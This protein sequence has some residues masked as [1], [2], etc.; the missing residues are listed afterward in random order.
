MESLLG[1]DWRW[2]WIEFNR[3]RNK[4]GD[5]DY[6]DDRSKDFKEHSGV[7]DYTDIFI[8]YLKLTPG[9]SVL[10]M[11]SGPGTIAI[12]LAKQGHPVIAADFSAGMR[13]MAQQRAE[14]LGLAGFEVRALD[15]NEDWVAAGIQP[16]SV[17]VAIASRSTMVDDLGDALMKLD[18]TA[19]H[20]VAL[21]MVT[22][23]SPRGF[24]ALGSVQGACKSYLPDYIYGINILLQLG[25]YPQLRYID[26]IHGN[27]GETENKL[28]R[29]AFIS[30]TPQ[31]ERQG[32]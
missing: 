6:W 12:P 13:Q 29:W 5:T 11:G 10:D 7:S 31:A 20:K 23:Y 19:R 32:Q 18:K 28:V 16:K 24:K 1:I 3:L 2:A 30:W 8:R 17:D 4:P 22:E 26:T 15:W 9:Q 27:G 21:T 14:E 25:I